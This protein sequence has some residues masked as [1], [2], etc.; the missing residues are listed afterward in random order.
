[1]NN[2]QEKR[3]IWTNE[4]NLEDWEDYFQEEEEELGEELTEYQKYEIAS[5]INN[6]I[7]YDDERANL[8]RRLPEDIICIADLGLWYGRRTGYKIMGD[9]LNSILNIGEDY[10]EYYADRFNIR[11]N[12]A[13]HDGTN[14][15]LFRMFR[16]GLSDEQKENFLNGEKTE[17]RIAR[18]T[19]S[20]LP[21]VAEVYGW[22]IDKRLS[23]PEHKDKARK[24][25]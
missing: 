16:P 10:N 1:M 5:E 23:L 17:S 13:H 18:Y 24:V 15:Y 11:A 22:S 3:I 20:L 21:Y 6:N 12:C 14:H 25:A 8:N 19:V 2:K 7:Y 9:N 4:I